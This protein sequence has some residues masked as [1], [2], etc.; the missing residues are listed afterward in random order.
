MVSSRSLDLHDWL[1]RQRWRWQF[2]T[3]AADERLAVDGV[4]KGLALIGE[5]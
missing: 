3:Y 2:S 5:Q 4:E 1:G